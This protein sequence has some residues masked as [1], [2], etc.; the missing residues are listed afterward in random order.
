[1]KDALLT[2]IFK[3]K[4]FWFDEMNL[5]ASMAERTV[6]A[7]LISNLPLE[8]VTKEIK[9]TCFPVVDGMEA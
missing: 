6:L 1:M 3:E 7:G 9:N 4:G 5:L 8:G 2:E